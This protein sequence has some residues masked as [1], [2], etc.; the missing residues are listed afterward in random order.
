M[1][2]LLLMVVAATAVLAHPGGGVAEPVSADSPI[3]ANDIIP[4]DAPVVAQGA[5]P[6]TPSNGGIPSEILRLGADFPYDVRSAGPDGYCYESTWSQKIDIDVVKCITEILIQIVGMLTSM[7]LVSVTDA[8]AI[9]ILHQHNKNNAKLQRHENGDGYRASRR[10]TSS[11]EEEGSL[12]DGESNVPVESD[13]V[14]APSRM[15]PPPAPTRGVTQLGVF[16][17]QDTPSRSTTGH[18]VASPPLPPPP[19]GTTSRQGATAWDKEKQAQELYKNNLQWP[20]R[21]ITDNDKTASMIHVLLKMIL[22]LMLAGYD[23][24][25]T[26][27]RSVTMPEEAVRQGRHMRNSTR[28][29]HIDF[30]VTS[31]VPQRAQISAADARANRI[32]RQYSKNMAEWEIRERGDGYRP[33]RGPASSSEEDSLL[34]DEST[35]SVESDVDSAPRRMPPPPP[36]PRRMTGRGVVPQHP[37]SGSTTR[38]RGAPPPLPPHPRGTTSRQGAFPPPAPHLPP[39]LPLSGPYPIRPRGSI[40]K[41]PADPFT[42]SPPLYQMPVAISSARRI[43]VR[44]EQANRNLSPFARSPRQDIFGPFTGRPVAFSP[45]TS[46]QNTA[47]LPP[48]PHSANQNLLLQQLQC[49][50]QQRS[51]G[52]SHHYPHPQASP[53]EFYSP[54]RHHLPPSLAPCSFLANQQIMHSSKLAWL[55]LILLPHQQYRNIFRL[56]FLST[57]FWLVVYPAFMHSGGE[58]QFSF[59]DNHNEMIFHLGIS[60]M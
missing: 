20:M 12:F 58:K 55:L 38:H 19:R 17:D 6:G 59:V 7:G 31:Q 44:R 15:P 2:N 22:T 36:P 54:Q 27:P 9:S 46:S 1:K 14:S 13:V 26:V 16:L 10:R 47:P 37:P 18:R 57:F 33:P 28:R 21:N 50:E 41:Q 24:A 4:G 51:L 35:A 30:D 48:S 40:T 8:N 11:S 49:F 52:S 60:D 53:P 39:P 34:D 29:Q 45:P 43:I 42:N 5:Q 56:L 23:I 3:I 32:L 25:S